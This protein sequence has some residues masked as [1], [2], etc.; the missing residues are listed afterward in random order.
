MNFF[1]NYIENVALYESK[2]LILREKLKMMKISRI[3]C[4]KKQGHKLND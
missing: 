2:T 3:W 1:E 4:H